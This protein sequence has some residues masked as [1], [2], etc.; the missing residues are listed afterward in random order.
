MGLY[1]HDRRARDRRRSAP[2]NRRLALVFAALL[3]MVPLLGVQLAS[4]DHVNNPPVAPHVVE[5]FPD[6]DFVTAAGY[7]SGETVTV[8]ALRA[9]GANPDVVVG[10]ATA[11]VGVD[12]IFEINHIGGA[13]WSVITP[14]LVAGDRV[15]VTTPDGHADE[16]TIRAMTIA[17]PGAQVIPP[18][19]TTVVVTGTAVGLPEAELEVRIVGAA[20]FSNG[21]RDIRAP[22]VQGGI[23]GTFEMDV[24]G[25]WTASWD[26]PL[27]SDLDSAL[28]G[29]VS[30]GWAGP[31]G[32]E[33]TQTE[34]GVFNGPG[35]PQ[36]PPAA[37]PI[38]SLA[39][40]TL[41]WAATEVGASK[42]V[43]ISNV[44]Q[45]V[46]GTGDLVVQSLALSGANAADWSLTDTCS[47]PVAP[48]SSCVVSLVFNPPVPVPGATSLASLDITD[49][50]LGSPHSVPL[51]GV[52]PA[53]V[54]VPVVQVVPTTLT[55][56]K[57]IPGN[58]SPPQD[59]VVTNL[60]NAPLIIDGISVTTSGTEF[61]IRSVSCLIPPPPPPPGP[62]QDL[63]FTPVD[64][65]ASCTIGVVFTPQADGPRTGTLT[66]HT[67][68]AVPTNYVV[69]LAG[70][71]L[72]TTGINDPPAAPHIVVPFPARDFISAEEYLEDQEWMI[73]V[74]RHGVV[75]GT[76]H[77]TGNGEPG[78]L[79]G[80][81]VFGV[82][83][84]GFVCWDGSTPDVRAGDIIRATILAGPEVG[85]DQTTVADIV[86]TVPAYVVQND[87][88]LTPEFEGTIRIEG[89]AFGPDGNSLPLS[90]LQQR[91]VASS[92][93]PFHVNGRRDIRAGALA[94]GNDGGTLW[95]TGTGPGEWMAEYVGLD[96][97]DVD[98]AVATQSRIMWLGRSGLAD[99]EVTI[100]EAG[101]FN[102]PSPECTAVA[103]AQ[104]PS[105][106][107]L[108]TPAA[109]AF[110]DRTVGTT[111][112]PLTLNVKNHGTAP[113]NVSL[114]APIGG[115]AADF[116]VD[117]LSDTCTGVAVAAGAT[118]TVQVTFTPSVAGPRA[119]SLSVFSDVVGSP[120]LVPLS[121]VG[122]GNPEP[123]LVVSPAALN[124][125]DTAV[126]STSPSQVLTL[127]NDGSAPL[128][129]DTTPDAT[130]LSGPAGADFLLPDTTCPVAPAAGIAPGTSCTLSV[131]FA[132]LA[133]GLRE[134]TLTIDS[135]APGV[136][137][138]ALSGTSL[139]IGQVDDPPAGGRILTLFPQRDFVD[140]E[141]YTPG[142]EIAV[143]VL[144][145]DIIVGR[146][147]ALADVNGLAGVNH[148]GGVC[149]DTVTPDIR[150]GDVVRYLR[151]WAG[152]PVL[153]DLGAS[154][155]ALTPGQVGEQAT[156]QNVVV[157]QPASLLPNGDVVT[158][159]WA[160]DT[161]GNPVSLPLLEARII[162]E[163]Q[164]R[165]QAPG[166]GVLT[167]D[168][169]GNWTATFS[170]LTPQQVADALAGESR[171]LHIN[172]TLSALTI[173]E[174][175]AVGG[176]ADLTPL[177]VS[178]PAAAPTLT[179]TPA[180]VDFGSVDV[181]SAPA[182]LA[183][184][185][186]TGGEIITIA[187]TTLDGINPGAFAIGANTCTGAVPLSCSIEVTFD[188][189]AE[190]AHFASLVVTSD[191]LGSPLI[192]PLTGVGISPPGLTGFSPPSGRPGTAVTL[193][194]VNLNDVTQVVF[195][196]GAGT[197]DDRTVTPTGATATD[198]TVSVPAGAMTGRIRVISPDGQADT[199]TDFLVTPASHQLSAVAV[200]AEV[201]LFSRSPGGDL[202]YRETTGG[203]FGAWTLVGSGLASRPEAV[204]VGSDLYVFFRGTGNDLRYLRRSGGT[205]SGLQSLGGV[206]TGQPVAAVD[207]AGNLVVAM[208]NGADQIW[209]RT[210][211]GGSWSGWTLM[212]GALRGRLE[213]VNH[214]GNL[215][216][217]GLNAAGQ[218]WTRAWSAASASWGTWFG[219]G[220]VL[221]GGPAAASYGGSLYMFGINPAGMTWYRA[222]TA[223]TWGPWT[224]HGGVLA[225]AP[226][227]AATAGG[228]VFAGVNLTGDPWAQTFTGSW[229]GW[230]ALGGKLAVG[231]ELVAAGTDVYTFGTS[232]A[233]TA[234][235]RKWN[236]TAWGPW[237]SLDGD[238]AME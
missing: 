226:D 32:T 103:P 76:A 174:F 98:L 68:N 143:L 8:Q 51:T 36:C 67:D 236:G 85:S 201:A 164:G 9:I 64:P 88:P 221:S 141:G 151:A 92:A 205:W 214:E 44:G 229:S 126:G 96:Q 69:D 111:S 168:P 124:F 57:R 212:D 12:G 62:G 119:S 176:P 89:T 190:G 208:L 160:L 24:D 185:L 147:L 28:G 182:S 162:F 42:D 120:A 237:T 230:Q 1:P 222:L 104:P 30:I 163:G 202:W 87:D 134:G 153:P 54:P 165:L 184:D 23:T 161:A 108:I 152:S 19:S 192:I 83:H 207:S 225:D 183:V 232:A 60:G 102:G 21:R 40:V 238:M 197:A 81:G 167:I 53:D 169:A 206:T 95:Y 74:I 172:P 145:S 34:Y 82:N 17:D 38:V 178:P 186:A 41:S 187:S 149:W 173:Y 94:E 138:V 107:H 188:P 220:G 109:L 70:E 121:G 193:T 2:I 148:P 181:A 97:H 90:Q 132:P 77:G 139:A 128:V 10:E 158:K 7:T 191:A 209:Y 215:H 91:I 16:T 33:G 146:A 142:A 101:E 171:I 25:N 179:P 144:R 6:R 118:C 125:P 52:V 79:P 200:G 194:G 115:D 113:L 105:P 170:G 56:V 131:A 65:A 231:P 127:T 59:I 195:L 86:V 26:L 50:A 14:N 133:V 73:E 106:D 235:Y 46:S 234:W 43:T 175:G 210:L 15:R 196:G 31:S 130:W 48:G 55:F 137:T 177:C 135:N 224:T 66:I 35:M 218:T 22:D 155:P 198:V 116:A 71:G 47:T 227:A 13:C 37:G 156:V 157:T 112:T 154:Y 122:I 18:G 233:G 211:T 204:S 189:A 4:A 72:A 75:V 78:G 140:S 20:D 45:G 49:N 80:R 117:P 180:A 5:A 114:I 129:L 199:A 219:F 217:F 123:T 61:A 223:G 100:Y 228:L 39:P 213:L 84:P 110:P 150:P 11:V 27:Q 136:H 159:G 63:L 166:D 93:D 58:T 216:L 99:T 3:A 29:A 203:T